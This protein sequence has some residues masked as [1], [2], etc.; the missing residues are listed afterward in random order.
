MDSVTVLWLVQSIKIEIYFAYL[1]P[2]NLSDL[3]GLP[4]YVLI[5]VRDDQSIS[6]EKN[7]FGKIELVKVECDHFDDSTEDST[8]LNS[9]DDALAVKMNED[10]ESGPVSR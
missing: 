1:S 10:I 4:D 8:H 6:D 2:S 3:N 7:E 5:A 9:N